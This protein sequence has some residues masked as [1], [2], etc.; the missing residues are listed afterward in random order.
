MGKSIGIK[1]KDIESEMLYWDSTLILYVLGGD[2]SMYMLKNYMECMW[3]FV[4][5]SYMVYHDEGY[6]IL[7]FRS[8]SDK[9]EMLIKG[10]YILRNM[11]LL[12]IDWKPGF[13][14]KEDMLR[15]LPG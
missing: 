11:P 13:S 3:S 9:E 10:P 8:D 15:T 6:F 7:E 4:Q 5:L 1:E 2:I 12:L 14:L